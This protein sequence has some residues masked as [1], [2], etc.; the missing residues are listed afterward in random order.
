MAAVLSTPSLVSNFQ[1]TSSLSGSLSALAPVCSGLPRKLGQS[2]AEATAATRVTSTETI[3]R[4]IGKTL[5]RS[6]KLDASLLLGKFVVLLFAHCSC[7]TKGNS[8]IDH[9][10]IRIIPDA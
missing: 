2:A 10:I 9:F 5:K 1:R 6:R 7:P 3:V 8:L 4:F